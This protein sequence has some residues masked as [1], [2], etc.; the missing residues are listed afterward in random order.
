MK[1]AMLGQKGIPTAFGG[2]ER[3]VE[4]LSTRLANRG[5]EVV[6]YCRPWYCQASSL[7]PQ[8]SSNLKLVSTASLKL[9]NLDAISHTFFSSLH[10][11]L[12]ER[13]D[14]YHYHG[15]GPALLAF[16]PRIF[17][18]RARVIVT[19]H[20]I[21]R[22]H[23]KWSLFARIMLRLG[24]WA[25]CRFAHRTITVSRTLSQYCRDVYETD[26]VYIPNGIS[27]HGIADPSLLKRFDLA[28][29]GYIAMVSR[30]VRHKGAHYLVEACN[31]IREERPELIQNKKLAIVGDSAF[32]D[33]YVQSL[34]GM[35]EGNP[36][37]VFTGYQSGA[38]LEALFSGA[39]FIV[40][41]SESEGLPIAVLEAMSYG[42][43][44][45]ASDIPENREV[46]AD[47]GFQFPSGDIVVL[48]EKIIDL[49]EHQDQLE[50]LGAE[51]RTFVLREYHWDDIATQVESLYKQL[52]I[53]TLATQSA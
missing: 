18:P 6:V 1:I 8:A 45:L 19:F 46:V 49:L 42:K 31:I 11:I 52:A 34:K 10:A 30:L 16:L 27:E 47:H 22:K 9:K 37:I 53:K 39:S 14:V 26:T 2:I 36:S 3:H 50:K 35:A 15:V 33:E 29:D 17:R 25:A 13:P 38:M 28:P 20:C 24:E 5:H 7:K 44:V 32:T 12:K 43:V 4:E 21:D 41:P 40:H 23:Q 48:K 51:A